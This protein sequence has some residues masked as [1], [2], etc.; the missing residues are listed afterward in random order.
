[1][2]LHD[3]IE[4]WED[5]SRPHAL[6][7]ASSAPGWARC[8]G[9]LEANYG[10][11]DTAGVDA[12]FGTV[13]HA[14]VEESL[15]AGRLVTENLG[16]KRRAEAGGTVYEFLIDDITLG[17]VKD[18]L[19]RVK[20]VPGDHF[21]ETRVVYDDLTPIKHQG[22][23]CDFFAC[24]PSRLVVKDWKFG[25]GVKVFVRDNEQPY[26]YAYGVFREWDWC[27]GFEE[28]EIEIVQ[29]RLEHYDKITITR[30][31]LLAFAE[32]VRVAAFRAW[33]KN[34]PRIPG[35]KQCQWCKKALKCAAALVIAEAEADELLDDL[36]PDN[37]VEVT[38]EV[39]RAATERL[40]DKEYKPRDPRDMD[41]ATIA[42]LYRW[43]RMMERWFRKAGDELLA[44]H[45]AG[46]VIPG[47]KAVQGRSKARF[48]GEDEAVEHVESLGVP[49]EKCYTKK[50]LSPAQMAEIIRVELPGENGKR[51]S[52]DKARKLLAPVEVNPPGERTLVPESDDREAL[53]DADGYLDDDDD[54]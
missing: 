11:P 47:Y 16:R 17:Y 42:R 23:T 52:R 34:A 1:M 50:L 33:E 6:F 40:P 19:D 37:P 27:Y 35:P 31:E 26:L 49:A 22:G 39:A 13:C 28:I 25:T 44:R 54:I 21:Y 51:M 45:D 3:D 46:E 10:E 2:G 53:P 48:V 24:Q 20:D 7:S 4:K 32:R 9:F 18:C 43:R 15:Q 41:T 8:P 5:P 30:E 36:D 12:A 14:L 29:P 38:S